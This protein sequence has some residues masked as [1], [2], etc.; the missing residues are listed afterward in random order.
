MVKSQNPLILFVTGVSCSG[1]STLMQ[2]LK[3]PTGKF[4]LTEIDEHGV[5]VVGRGPWR[6]F[7]VEE[8][9]RDA[10]E[11]A[12][13]GKSTIIFKISKSTLESRLRERLL[14]IKIESKVHNTDWQQAFIDLVRENI[15]L[16]RILEN[17]TLNQK[18]G[19]IFRVDSWTK[20][21]LTQEATKLINK[22]N[23]F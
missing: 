15:R 17:S 16:D 11:N 22:I 13:A 21:K 23:A 6:A 20:T 1:K 3:L 5:P 10:I 7:R 14:S 4:V 2:N 12:K 19:H 18:N 8:L 9:T